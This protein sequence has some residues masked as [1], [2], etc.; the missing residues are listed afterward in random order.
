MSPDAAT[1]T[2]P[3]SPA[4]LAG[5]K[6]GIE[7]NLPIDRATGA[8]NMQIRNPRVIADTGAGGSGSTSSLAPGRALLMRPSMAG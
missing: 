5:E 2:Q 3:A 8:F 6:I 4:K 1:S 7:A